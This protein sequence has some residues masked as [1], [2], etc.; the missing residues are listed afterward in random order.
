MRLRFDAESFF[1]L[2]PT[3]I[4]LFSDYVSTVLL[5]TYVTWNDNVIYAGRK[6]NMKRIT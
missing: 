2:Y 1:I 3:G 5:L 6:G 4:R